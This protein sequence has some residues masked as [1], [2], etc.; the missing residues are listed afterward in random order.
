[1]SCNCG[2]VLRVSVHE[3]NTKKSAKFWGVTEEQIDCFDTADI[4]EKWGVKGRVDGWGG[5]KVEQSR[6]VGCGRSKVSIFRIDTGE[7]I[8]SRG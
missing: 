2:G 6:C 3:V 5:I 8:L 1:M 7:C 4:A